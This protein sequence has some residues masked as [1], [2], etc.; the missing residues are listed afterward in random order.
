M[1]QVKEN[2]PQLRKNTGLHKLE[3]LYD[4]KAISG[5]KR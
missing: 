5:H 2:F 4:F 3:A 1:L